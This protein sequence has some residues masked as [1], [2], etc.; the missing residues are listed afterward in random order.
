MGIQDRDYYRREVPGGSARRSAKASSSTTRHLAFF[1]AWLALMGVMYLGV[2][3]YLAPPKALVTAE[4]ELHIP[5]SRDGHFYIDGAVNGFAVTFLVDTGATTVV[6]DE[7]L[8]KRARLPKGVPT[9][10]QTANGL[11]A[12]RT[13]TGVTVQA[14]PFSVSSM[15]VG[16]G[17]A[18]PGS[19]RALLG[20]NF[21]SKFEVAISSKEMVLRAPD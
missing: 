2:N 11:L 20:Q 10:F 4:G 7:A 15:R 19:E 6:V 5:R 8:A 16:V 21:L 12:G 14:G 9:T 3:A 18:G 1:F 17:L 13:V